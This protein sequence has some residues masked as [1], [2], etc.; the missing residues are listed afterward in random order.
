M[1]ILVFS[2]SHG[3]T[4][5]MREALLTHK[6]STDL[7]YFL[8]DGIRDASLVL[9]EFPEIPRVL[10]L[11]NCDSP[12]AAYT[13]GVPAEREDLRTLDG[14]KILAMHGD[15]AGVKHGT[16]RLLY[17]ASEAGAHLALFGHTHT[18]LNT[19]AARPFDPERRVLLFNPGSIGGPAHSYGV[20]YVVGGQ[21]S[22]DHG[23][24]S[25]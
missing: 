5:A 15:A 10:L 8:G 2:D 21:I 9:S 23:H 17:R 12:F 14:V 16:E 18:P 3:N 6:G 25:R 4:D 11:G 24:V 22:A 1:K 7:V 13:A 19:F 20:I